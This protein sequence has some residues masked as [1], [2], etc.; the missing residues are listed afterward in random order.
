[1]VQP[2]THLLGLGPRGVCRPQKPAAHTPLSIH[3]SLLELETRIP[4]RHCLQPLPTR[5]T[6]SLSLSLAQRLHLVLVHCSS[7]T[8]S[9]QHSAALYPSSMYPHRYKSPQCFIHPSR[10]TPPE[11]TTCSLITLPSTPA[12]PKHSPAPRVPVTAQRVSAVSPPIQPSGATRCRT[13]AIASTRPVQTA[14]RGRR[15]NQKRGPNLI[16]VPTVIGACNTLE[17]GDRGVY[18]SVMYEVSAEGR[19]PSLMPPE[20]IPRCHSGSLTRTSQR[21]TPHRVHRTLT[22]TQLGGNFTQGGGRLGYV[23]PC[24]CRCPAPLPLTPAASQH[25]CTS[26]HFGQR[27]TTTLARLTSRDLTRSLP[28]WPPP[29]HWCH[30]DP[31]L[32]HHRPT[33]PCPAR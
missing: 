11:L 28:S 30:C 14:L 5:I 7:V 4:L 6:P 8:D 23:R 15:V 31:A 21:H 18:M 27:A 25:N 17:A 19:T 33:P 32:P 24:L 1:M 2:V 12:S 22:L 20:S 13:R 9:T 26:L 10:P 16:N 29:T 3:S